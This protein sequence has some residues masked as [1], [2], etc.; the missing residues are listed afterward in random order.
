MQHK[1]P[2]SLEATRKENL[3]LAL[4]KTEWNG[5]CQIVSLIYEDMAKLYHDEA[6]FF[7]VDFEKETSL[8]KEFGIVEVPTILFFKNGAL[9]D[10]AV[11]MTAKNLLIAK[12]ESALNPSN[13]HSSKNI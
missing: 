8:S 11:G 12:I 3:S 5:A 2:F 7:T 4:F 6:D 13:D 10:H 9:V 1:K